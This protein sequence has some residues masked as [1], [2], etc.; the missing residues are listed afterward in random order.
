MMEQLQNNS[1]NDPNFA[2]PKWDTTFHFRFDTTFEGGGMSHFFHFSPFSGDS[3]MQGDFFGFD[4]FFDRFFNF[5]N[6]F[7]RPGDSE[8]YD[9]PSDDGNQP[10]AGEDGLLPEE[11]LR[12]QEGPDKSKDKQSGGQPAPPK[13]E[14]KIKTIRI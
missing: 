8:T 10:D 3:T 2:M 6:P 13:P 9:F 11:R 7:D 4:R 14:R 5:E 12:R 1:F